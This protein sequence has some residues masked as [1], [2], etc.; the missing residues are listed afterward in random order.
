MER[1]EQRREKMRK[2]MKKKEEERIEEGEERRREKGEG[3]EKRGGE[4]GGY[5][6]NLRQGALQQDISILIT[7]GQRHPSEEVI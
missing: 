4:R 1:G 7:G 2:G 3:R 5:R 6:I